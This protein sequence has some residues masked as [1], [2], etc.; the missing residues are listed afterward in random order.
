[1]FNC[2][3][4]VYEVGLVDKIGILEQAK[5]SLSRALRVTHCYKL[6]YIIYILFNHYI[7]SYNPTVILI[8]TQFNAWPLSS[9]TL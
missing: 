1:M 9:L 8:L 4:N 2:F 7:I 3:Q 6:K 5:R